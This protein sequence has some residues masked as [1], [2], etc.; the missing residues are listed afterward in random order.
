MLGLADGAKSELQFQLSFITK[1]TH[2]IKI[3]DPS[4]S[5]NNTISG[6]SSKQPSSFVYCHTI[7][8]MAYLAPAWFKKE[9]KAEKVI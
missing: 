5:E 9:L 7:G 8:W 4:K 1:S 3:Y 2:W 6:V